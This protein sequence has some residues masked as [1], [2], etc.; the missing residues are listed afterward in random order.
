[1][2]NDPIDLGDRKVVGFQHVGDD[3]SDRSDG[4]PVDRLPI[5]RDVPGGGVDREAA[6][7]LGFAFQQGG[8]EAAGSDLLKENRRS[9]V[10]KEDARVSIFP[11]DHGGEGFRADHEGVLQRS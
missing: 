1:M 5:H 10:A 9:T 7:L 2:G 8:G 3:L 11:I 6:R 4:E